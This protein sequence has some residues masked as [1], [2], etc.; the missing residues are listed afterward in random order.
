MGTHAAVITPHARAP[1]VDAK[2][3]R[4]AAAIGEPS[5]RATHRTPKFGEFRAP[6][7]LVTRV[8]ERL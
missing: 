4:S 5:E 1:P 7:S 8:W 2:N 3:I 6:G